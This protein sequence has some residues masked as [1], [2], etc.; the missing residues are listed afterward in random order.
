MRVDSIHSRLQFHRVDLALF[1]SFHQGD[2]LGILLKDVIVRVTAPRYRE[3]GHLIVM[4][5]YV[6]FAEKV[7][8]E[9]FQ[10][11]LWSQT[12]TS[13]L[14]GTRELPICQQV[15]QIQTNILQCS[16]FELLDITRRNDVKKIADIAVVHYL[17]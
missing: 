11:S 8:I 15:L 14:H 17:N 16:I 1:V 2:Q 4:A 9:I 13:I 12:R 10:E 7:S 5:D 6:E 3:T